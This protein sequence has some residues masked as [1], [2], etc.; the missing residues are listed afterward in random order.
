MRGEAG[1]PHQA[2]AE[3]AGAVAG[4]LVERF[5]DAC[6]QGPDL[7]VT[8]RQLQR[9][10]EHEVER[11]VVGTVVQAVRMCGGPAQHR[12]EQPAL[13]AERTVDAAPVKPGGRHQV[14]DRGSL[15]AETA[16]GGACRVQDDIG[17]EGSGAGH[18]L[19]TR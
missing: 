15:E 11:L 6:D 17:I 12:Q 14:I 5:A 13:A 19:Q 18:V 3:H 9:R 2:R 16:E 4:P 1:A 7:I 10:D 8:R